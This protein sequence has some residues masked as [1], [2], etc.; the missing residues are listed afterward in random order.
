MQ[1]LTRPYKMT[2]HA[3]AVHSPAMPTLLPLILGR[4]ISCLCYVLDVLLDISLH[5]VKLAVLTA[6]NIR[7]CR[8]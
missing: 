1:P 2:C 3:L 8:A 4:T 7:T 5:L 6:A